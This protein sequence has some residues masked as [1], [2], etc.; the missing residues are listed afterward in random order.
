MVSEIPQYCLRAFAL[1]YSRHGSKEPFAQ[2]DLDWIVGTS[3]KKKIFSI[4]LKSGW[5]RKASRN[6][7]T[8][9]NPEAIFRGMLAFKVPEIIK[10]AERKYAFTQLS[11]VEI[12]SDY[13][14]VQ[15][16]VDRSPYYIKV[17]REDIE[18]WKSF[19]NQN[20]IPNYVGEGHTIGEFVIL[21]PVGNIDAIE[22]HGVS[23]ERLNE[24]IAFA[25]K[26]D[27]YEYALDYMREKYGSISS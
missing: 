2:S 10:K 4:L 23:V 5:I 18:Y 3:M 19:F 12:W 17:L 27:T 11:A 9:M 13:S 25:K 20:N 7:Y 21:I 1:F 22:R 24:A 16:S 8:C 6:E 26:N 15:R 14:Y